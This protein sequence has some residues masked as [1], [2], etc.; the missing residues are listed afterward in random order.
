[1]VGGRSKQAEVTPNFMPLQKGLGRFRGALSGPV[2]YVGHFPS[3]ALLVHLDKCK[4]RATNEPRAR[5]DTLL[6]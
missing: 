1:M 5:E 6:I 4:E 2:G 3:R